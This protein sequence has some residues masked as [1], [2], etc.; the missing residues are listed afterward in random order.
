MKQPSTAILKLI[1]LLVIAVAIILIV[2]LLIVRTD[3]GTN[4]PESPTQTKAQTT[5]D[6]AKD[7]SGNTG[8]TTPSPTGTSPGGNNSLLSQ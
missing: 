3:H 2:V 6:P 1:S 8:D 5:P 4:S 7:D